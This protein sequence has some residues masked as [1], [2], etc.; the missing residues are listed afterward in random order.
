VDDVAEFDDESIESIAGFAGSI[1]NE[2]ILGVGKIG[3]RIITL[4]NLEKLMKID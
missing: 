2:Y 3:K 4:L 1:T